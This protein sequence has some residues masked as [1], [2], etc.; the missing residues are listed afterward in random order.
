MAGFAAMSPPFWPSAS[1]RACMPARPLA[2]TCKTL[3]RAYDLEKFARKMRCRAD[4]GTGVIEFVRIGLGALDQIR[5]RI[6]A[7]F[8]IDQDYIGR[9]AKLG[10]RREILVGIVRDLCVQAGIDDVR[11]RGD[12]ERIAVRLGVGR[13]AD[14]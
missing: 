10:D 1:V 4:A 14:P 13:G 2:T 8:G 5:D 9:G 12:Q 3:L 6:D 7:E 11:A